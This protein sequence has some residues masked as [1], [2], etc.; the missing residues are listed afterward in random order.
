[1]QSPKLNKTCFFIYT[2]SSICK[3]FQSGERDRA[4][5]AETLEIMPIGNC[6]N[7]L[8]EFEVSHFAHPTPISSFSISVFRFFYALLGA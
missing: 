2:R 1:M 5:Q 7:F 8:I 4:L 6:H 3:Q